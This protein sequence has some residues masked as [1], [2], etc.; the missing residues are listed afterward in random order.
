[1][2]LVGKV[3][4]F[5]EVGPLSDCNSKMITDAAKEFLDGRRF[6]IV[7][8]TFVIIHFLFGVGV[9]TYARVLSLRE[10][11]KFSCSVDAQSTN[12]HKKQVD[13]TCLGQYGQTYN[14][15]LPLFD[16]AILSFGCAILVSISYSLI[17]RTRVDEIESSYASQND[18]KSKTPVV[19]NE[20]S[21]EDKAK[22][23]ENRKTVYV[24][25]SYFLHLVVRVSLGTAFTAAQYKYFNASG[26]PV[27]FTC[28][29]NYTAV[30]SCENP[31]ASQKSLASILVCV[32]NGTVV[33]FQFAEVIYLSIRLAIRRRR[34]KD[35]INVDFEFVIEYFL[36]KKYRDTTSQAS[37]STGSSTGNT[38]NAEE[39]L[40]EILCTTGAN[41]TQGDSVPLTVNSTQGVVRSEVVHLPSTS[42]SDA[43]EYSTDDTLNADC[44]IIQKECT[45]IMDNSIQQSISKYKD[46]VLKRRSREINYIPNK[47][48]DDFYVDIVFQPGRARDELS[49]DRKR[50]KVDDIPTST[51]S[52]KELFQPNEDT[53]KDDTSSILVVG[54]PGIGKTVLTEK[55]LRDWAN[56]TDDHYRDKVAC[57]VKI[58]NFNAGIQM[59]SD[60]SLKE[61]LHYETSLT[62]DEFERIYE[63]ITDKPQNAILIFDGLDEFN[64]NYMDY[65]DEVNRTPN[66]PDLCM[67][68]MNLFVKLVRGDILKGATVLV[69]S[70][71]SAA[72][73]YA[74][75][76]F[77]QEVEICG[78][79]NDQIQAYVTRF[80]E[81]QETNNLKPKILEHIESTP[82][83]L[84]LC[85]IPVTCFLVCVSLWGSLCDSKSTNDTSA[86]PTTLTD[87][88]QKVLCYFQTYEQNRNDGI[89]VYPVK[90]ETLKKLQKLAFDGV[91]N[92]QQFFNQKQVDEQ[93]KKSCFLNTLS[94]PAFPIEAEFCF[95]HKT[96]QEFLAAKHVTEKN[97][98]TKIKKFI[99]DHLAN[100][101]W[102]MVLLFIAG[103]L[104]KEV[105]KLEAQKLYK[106]CVLAFTDVSDNTGNMFLKEMDLN[107]EIEKDIY[108]IAGM[109]D[110]SSDVSSQSR[111]S[112]IPESTS[113]QAAVPLVC[114]QEEDL[115]NLNSHGQHLSSGKI[116]YFQFFQCDLLFTAKDEQGVQQVCSHLAT[117]LSSTSRSEDAFVWLATA[118]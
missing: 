79:E 6:G 96:L 91:K 24:F 62:D 3:I 83:L 107:V 95:I 74:K 99:S 12:V 117:N 92:G 69:T 86:L 93:I 111:K 23:H 5:S 110:V 89:D 14:S 84:E 33:L 90:E 70:R 52:I 21:N 88:F 118:C 45:G 57:I 18:G 41:N 37:A 25:V 67:P 13:Q 63:E 8:Y 104:G 61:F 85:K 73:S 102:Q 87:L 108:N 59:S 58:R 38:Q 2:R 81:N 115:A 50:E 66:K 77:T 53:A 11:E 42:K 64:G 44:G 82:K 60:V 16:L 29:Y 22:N 51:C 94:N 46:E 103:L 43:Q 28:N 34:Y 65:L 30:V 36:G 49:K 97:N 32:A 15:P 98:V 9:T 10:T 106:D 101:R 80:C 55:I 71:P 48:L 26:F 20:L 27:K 116:N 113:E 78:F 68:P 109:G 105:K 19:D 75:I 112:D 4:Y 31:T 7:G 35:S 40:V 54:R 1:M 47:S 114:K 17:V 76:G 72:K 39:P 56:E 100:K